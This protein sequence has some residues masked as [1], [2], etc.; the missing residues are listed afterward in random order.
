MLLQKFRAL[1]LPKSILH[2]VKFHSVC[3]VGYFRDRR[4]EITWP[5]DKNF[6]LEDHAI[7]CDAIWRAAFPP[8]EED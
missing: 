5:R 7:V 2:G 6:V 8:A 1:D 4:E 3:N